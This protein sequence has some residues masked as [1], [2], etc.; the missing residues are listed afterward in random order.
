MRRKTVISLLLLAG[1][2]GCTPERLPEKT[3][4]WYAA[5]EDLEVSETV[6]FTEDPYDFTGPTS[7]ADA[8]AI[9]ADLEGVTLFEPDPAMPT[10][11]EGWQQSTALPL[12]IEGIATLRPRYYYKSA[13]CETVADNDS[14]EK[15]FGSFFIE[16]SSGGAFVL[17]DTKVPH[18]E[19]GDRVKLRVRALRDSY[20]VRMIA[21]HDVIE[22][23][24]GPEAI[25]YQWAD[26]ELGPDDTG[27][28]R[29]LT[30]TVEVP[31][32]TDSF[33]A[34][35][36]RD[37]LGALHHATIDVELQRRGITV[38]SG[39]RVTITGPVFFNSYEDYHMIVLMRLGQIQDAT[40][41]E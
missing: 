3:S 10:Q 39:E 33:G 38:E 9:L 6:L 5:A 18:F 37:D 26:G 19:M 12:E 20:G 1:V 2:V 21:A 8:M 31:P 29:R 24:R 4:G 17:G 27:E 40:D 25:Y 28:V 7:I 30:A 32:T 41:L 34:F 23:I 13:G 15:Y 22:V 16:D 11:C 14:D 36:L 35:T